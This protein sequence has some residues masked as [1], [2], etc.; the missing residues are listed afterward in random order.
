MPHLGLKP[1]GSC[2][3]GSSF[4][5]CFDMQVFK[6]H[7]SILYE[8]QSE[9]THLISQESKEKA[10]SILEKVGLKD[11][12]KHNITT[13]SG[14]EKQRVAIARALMLS[15]KIILADEPTGN[16]DEK[17]ADNIMKM[18]LELCK[19]EGVALLLITHNPD[20]ALRTNSQYFLKEG[21]FL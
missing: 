7:I 3:H 12:Y 6:L 21:K 16:L 17:S 14:G 15:P 9:S 20:F 19:N 18:F 2:F 11:R 4:A 5:K 10:L 8:P 13:L 1:V